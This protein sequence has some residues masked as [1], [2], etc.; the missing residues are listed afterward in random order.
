MLAVAGD[1]AGGGLT[2][3]MLVAARDAGLP[4]PA[5]AVPISP[6]TDL[7]GTGGSMTSQAGADAMVTG[8]GLKQMADYYLAGQDP[9]APTA[10]P[11]YADLAG[12]PPMLVHVGGAEILLDDSRRLAEK[13][14]ADGV[15]VTL[16][17]WD[18]MP[19]VWHIFC[20]L[21]PEATQACSRVGDGTLPHA[22]DD[23]AQAPREDFA[24][25]P[26]Q[27][28]GHGHTQELPRWAPP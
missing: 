13:A 12:L 18:D 1:S 8:D 7:E 14:E 16:E 27:A 25:G 28:G 11:I 22:D 20:G 23:A 21:L 3:A 26:F 19:H 4:M 2:G 17:V 9:R 15:D 6:W 24:P 10:S 5:A